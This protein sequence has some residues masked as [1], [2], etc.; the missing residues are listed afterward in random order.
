MFGNKILVYIRL[1]VN[2]EAVKNTRYKEILKTMDWKERMSIAKKEKSPFILNLLARD[3][4][5]PVRDVCA[6]N[7]NLS[8]KT[9][10][11][12]TT[13]GNRY[14]R[15]SA[16]KKYAERYPSSKQTSFLRV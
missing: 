13:D 14:V 10:D 6:L 15:E 16:R 9:L 11:R 12:L 5:W 4:M 3:I 1:V 2:M 8:R 7:I